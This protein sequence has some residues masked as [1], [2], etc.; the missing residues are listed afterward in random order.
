MKV[1]RCEFLRLDIGKPEGTGNPPQPAK[2]V[3]NASKEEECPKSRA[4][5]RISEWCF[6]VRED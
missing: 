1:H 5:L 4:K 6:R 3:C 2:A